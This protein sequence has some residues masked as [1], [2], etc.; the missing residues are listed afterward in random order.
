MAD[1]CFTPTL[2]GYV[3]LSLTQGI[4]YISILFLEFVSLIFNLKK[5]EFWQFFLFT[6]DVHFFPVETK[7]SIDDSQYGTLRRMQVFIPL[8]I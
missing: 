4:T 6:C 1:W 5:F 3:P 7:N 8:Y 2:L